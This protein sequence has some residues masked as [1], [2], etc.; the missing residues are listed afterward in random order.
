MTTEDF[1]NFFVFRGY[2]VYY[3][4]L[5]SGFLFGLIQFKRLSLAA[6]GVWMIITVSLFLELIGSYLS[7][8]IRNS[9][10]STHFVNIFHLLAY[11]YAFSK[12]ATNKKLERGFI[13][14]GILLACFAVINLVWIQ[15]LYQSP[16]KSTMMLNVAVVL[17]SLITFYT[18]IKKPSQTP[19]L[20]QELFWFNTATLVF[21]SSTF[22]LFCLVRLLSETI[23]FN[24]RVHARV[25]HKSGYRYELLYV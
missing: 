11:A 19:L 10:P 24:R 4:I 12:Y 21:Y 1:L 8:V 6:R 20:K 25:G 3:L 17:G 22:F 18:M 23:L 14:A 5:I 13:I 16:T 7:M 2:A 15:G 9:S